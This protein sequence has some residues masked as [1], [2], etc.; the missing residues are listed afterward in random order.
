MEY[1]LCVFVLDCDNKLVRFD[2]VPLV[3]ARLHLE[4]AKFTSETSPDAAA[5][6]SAYWNAVDL[7]RTLHF[8][9]IHY[10]CIAEQFGFDVVPDVP[11]KGA[12]SASD[13]FYEKFFTLKLVVILRK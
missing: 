11:G 8:Y 12:I 3:L 2:G 4:T 9:V 7:L 13:E 5:A 1:R 6:D 10:D